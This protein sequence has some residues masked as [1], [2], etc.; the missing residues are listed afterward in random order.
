MPF[1]KLN[2]FIASRIRAVEMTGVVMR[3]ASFTT[4]SWMGAESPLMFVWS[5]NTLDALLLTWCAAIK[6]DPAYTL[7]NAFWILVGVIGMARAANF[8]H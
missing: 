7:L 6:R 4:V 8:L 3:I 5:F 2:H 1:I